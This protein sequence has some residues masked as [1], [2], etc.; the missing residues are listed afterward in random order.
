MSTIINKIFACFFKKY[1]FFL[2]F[3]AFGGRGSPVDEKGGA[4]KDKREK[5]IEKGAEVCYTI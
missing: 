4:Q 1:S 2:R 5:P 3:L